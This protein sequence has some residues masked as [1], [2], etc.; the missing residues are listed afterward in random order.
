MQSYLIHR[1][2]PRYPDI[3]R[4]ARVEGAVL[5]R[6]VISADGRIEQAQ[7]V[8]GSP[9]LSGA[10]LDAIKQWR[11]RPYFLNDKPVEVE[12]EITVNFYLTR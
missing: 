4:V 11:Y 1:V 9:L 10:A 7:V 8:N 3:A 2:E 12:T 6:A 5:I